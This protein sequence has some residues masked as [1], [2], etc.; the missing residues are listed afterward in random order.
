MSYELALHRDLA[1]ATPP[2]AGGLKL[3]PWPARERECRAI[4]RLGLVHRWTLVVL[5][6]CAFSRF[7]LPQRPACSH[8]QITVYTV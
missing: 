6:R 4:A 8:T 7:Q 3:G 2:L 1:P 5:K